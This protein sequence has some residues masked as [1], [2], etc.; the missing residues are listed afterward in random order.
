[1]ADNRATP[2]GCGDAHVLGRIGHPE[3]IAEVVASPTASFVTGAL[4]IADVGYTVVWGGAVLAQPISK[5][6][7]DRPRGPH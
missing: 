6:P 3:E 4:I 2:A 5:G 7:R 1:M